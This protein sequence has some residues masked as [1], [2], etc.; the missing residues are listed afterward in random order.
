MSKADFIKMFGSELLELV[1]KK[2][3][4]KRKKR[5][6]IKKM[7]NKKKNDT[8]LFPKPS[9]I[10]VGQPYSGSGSGSGSI[11]N[12][13]PQSK[14][15]VQIVDANK[16]NKQDDKFE[17]YKDFLE[18]GSSSNVAMNMDEFCS[19]FPIKDTYR[20]IVLY[21]TVKTHSFSSPV[22]E[23]HSWLRLTYSNVF[24]M[25]NLLQSPTYDQSNSLLGKHSHN[26]V[27]SNSCFSRVAFKCDDMNGS[28]PS[29]DTAIRSFI[30]NNIT[31]WLALIKS[32]P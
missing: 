12:N 14:N 4:S 28:G 26:I 10:P 22:L 25:P 15:P 19:S 32:L 23:N 18:F 16:D 5:K 6:L 29:L 1:L 17:K 9:N 20:H 11:I 13:I 30:S 7:N 31:Q 24:G 21:E 27:W 3:K 2:K 8:S